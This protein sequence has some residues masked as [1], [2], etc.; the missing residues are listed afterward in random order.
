MK[1]IPSIAWGL[2]LLPDFRGED[3]ILGVAEVIP[4]QSVLIPGQKQKASCL[5]WHLP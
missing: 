2:C 3:V 4:S 1:S 5:S